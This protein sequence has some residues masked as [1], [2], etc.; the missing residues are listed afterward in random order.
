MVIRL[1]RTPLPYGRGQF[2]ESNQLD[3][4]PILVKIGDTH[5]IY[6]DDSS[7]KL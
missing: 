4:A 5:S 1:N 7:S 2:V 6:F 3:C